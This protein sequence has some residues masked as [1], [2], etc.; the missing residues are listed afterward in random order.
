MWGLLEQ[1]EKD[2]DQTQLLSK[3]RKVRGGSEAALIGRDYVMQYLSS[4]ANR[5][6]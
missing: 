5:E 1:R 2:Q 3:V 6:S 4:G